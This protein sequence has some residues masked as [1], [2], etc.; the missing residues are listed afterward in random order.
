M[1]KKPISP[2]VR[3]QLIY[4]QREEITEYH[5]YTR[6]AEQIKDNANK[7]VLQQI[8]A[9]L[10][11]LIAI[12]VISMTLGFIMNPARAWANYLLNNYYFVSLAVG[13]AFY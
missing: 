9:L 2:E 1:I 3:Q 6:L 7:K 10:F 5:I 12:G 13:A 11:G 8:A 4:A